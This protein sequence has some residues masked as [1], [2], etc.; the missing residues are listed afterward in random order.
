[1]IDIP[2]ILDRESIH[3][4]FQSSPVI[5]LG[6]IFVLAMIRRLT[7]FDW[8]PIRLWPTTL[9]ACGLTF[10]GFA[11]REAFDVGVVKDWWGKSYIDDAMH[12]L[13][14]IFL[15]IAIRKIEQW[16]KRGYL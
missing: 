1:M 10:L 14:L 5:A 13:A 16:V 15:C 9:L 12:A 11:L 7:K 4:G 8:L 2:H 3:L 6:V